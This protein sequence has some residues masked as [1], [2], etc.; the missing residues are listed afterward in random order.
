MRTELKKTEMERGVFRGVFSKYGKKTNFRGP[1]TETILLTEI[2][3]SEG[4]FICDHLWFNLTKGFGKLGH[5]REGEILQFEARVKSY[6]KGYINKSAGI[7]ESTLD[8]K[9]SHPTKMEKVRK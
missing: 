4:L 9:L 1:S 5:L 6:K 3:N 7:N 2:R 8:Y